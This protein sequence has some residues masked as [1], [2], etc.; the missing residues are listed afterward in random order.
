MPSI[1]AG[2]TA[3]HSRRPAFFAACVLAIMLATL[4]ST[5]PAPAAAA[6]TPPGILWNYTVAAAS[7]VTAS[8]SFSCGAR[9]RSIVVASDAR[10]NIVSGIDLAT[11]A[12]LYTTS[13]AGV[14]RFVVAAAGDN[15]D[16]AVVTGAVGS[17]LVAVQ[18][19]TGAVLWTAMVDPSEF[20]PGAPS[21]AG[22]WVGVVAGRRLY[23]IAARASAGALPPPWT[24]NFTMAAPGES[25][26][27]G[28]V[29]FGPHRGNISHLFF[30]DD[31]MMMYAVHIESGAVLWT[32]PHSAMIASANY[33]YEWSIGMILFAALDGHFHAHSNLTGATMWK[34]PLPLTAGAACTSALAADDAAG[35]VWFGCSDKRLLVLGRFTA[36]DS[37]VLY[38]VTDEVFNAAIVGGVAVGTGDGFVYTADA[39][40]T[41][42]ALRADNPQLGAVATWTPSADPASFAPMAVPVT[43]RAPDTLPTGVALVGSTRRLFVLGVRDV[44]PTTTTTTSTT[45]MPG[46]GGTTAPAVTLLVFTVN[47]TTPLAP[48]DPTAFVADLLARVGL[49]PAPATR[50]TIER[51]DPLGGPLYQLRLGFASPAAARTVLAMSIADQ[52]ALRLASFGMYAPSTS[53]APVPRARVVDALNVAVGVTVGLLVAFIAIFVYCAHRSSQ[54]L[55]PHLSDT[56]TATH[57]N[58]AFSAASLSTARP[59]EWTSGHTEMTI[60]RD[61][62]STMNGAPPPSQSV[63]SAASTSFVASS[64]PFATVTASAP[65]SPQAGFTRFDDL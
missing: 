17:S 23:A 10:A 14:G 38:N 51:L 39:G 47:I 4:L 27:A 29:L 35:T 30:M 48:F 16:F 56:R 63:A 64:A 33:H 3:R 37:T 52:M 54:E 2:H 45:A 43:P 13:I 28:P 61:S 40:G 6:A 9:Y 1:P 20:I 65:G 41:I 34:T 31:I 57:T 24:L 60:M 50:V 22:G 8:T 36:L 11:G 18:P 12:R 44:P 53:A 32:R 55:G 49:P 26:T 15:V 21:V 19:S 42:Y 7:N 5:A 62:E 58:F 25:S 59:S 46:G